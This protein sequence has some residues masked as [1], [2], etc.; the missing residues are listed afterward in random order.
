MRITNLKE[1]KVNQIL[2]QIQSKYIRTFR[3]EGKEKK[4]KKHNKQA[5]KKNI[6]VD[7]IETINSD[8]SEL[9]PDARLLR[10][11]DVITQDIIFKRQNILYKLAVYHSKS[12]GKIY[13]AKKPAGE[14]Y[15]SDEL[16]SS[17][18]RHQKKSY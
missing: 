14:A 6:P 17:A 1:N 13:R 16:K 10:Y 8:K 11:D 18:I 4:S 9:P 3:Q 2:K 5:K 7:K 15:H 12:T